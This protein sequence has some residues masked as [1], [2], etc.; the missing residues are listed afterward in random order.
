[1]TLKEFSKDVLADMKQSPK[2]WIGGIAAMVF[3]LGSFYLSLAAF[4]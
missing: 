2:E 4:G 3:L 1:M